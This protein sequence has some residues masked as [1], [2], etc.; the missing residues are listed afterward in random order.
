MA[1]VRGV[2]DSDL[3]RCVASPRARYARQARSDQRWRRH[4]RSWLNAGGR[5]EERV[6][7]KSG[8]KDRVFWTAAGTEERG[9]SGERWKD[10]WRCAQRGALCSAS[11]TAS[12]APSARLAAQCRCWGDAWSAGQS[13]GRPGASHRAVGFPGP[14]ILRGSA[15]CAPWPPPPADRLAPDPGVKVR[16]WRECLQ[17]LEGGDAGELTLCTGGYSPE[18]PRA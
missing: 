17:L 9:G 3:E 8:Q 16:T 7:P 10:D 11:N 18:A 5:V 12:G 2:R 15:P 1:D 6:R 14:L 13:P 4:T